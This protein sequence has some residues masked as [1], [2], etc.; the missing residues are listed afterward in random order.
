ME[1]PNF[2]NFSNEKGDYTIV[3]DR[4][5]ENETIV[6]Y[7]GK[8]DV[9]NNSCRALNSVLF[10]ERKGKTPQ[11]KNGKLPILHVVGRSELLI[12]PACGC[13]KVLMAETTYVC[14]NK[15][16]EHHWAN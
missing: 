15:D 6:G 2:T 3:Y 13:N 5:G 7:T 12:C 1:T 10:I 16:C 8:R 11:L 4:N 14:R 9:A